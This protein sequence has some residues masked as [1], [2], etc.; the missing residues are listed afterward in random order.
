MLSACASSTK[1]LVLPEPVDLRCSARCE[2]SCQDVEPIVPDAEG[3]AEVGTLLEAIV[4]GDSLL[5]DCE[6]ARQECVECINRG[7]TIGVIR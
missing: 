4:I 5:D 7:R 6:L 3:K 1:N 2:S